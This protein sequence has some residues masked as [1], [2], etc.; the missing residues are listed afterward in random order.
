GVAVD[1]LAGCHA[2]V[3]QRLLQRVV[4][5]GQAAEVGD[6]L[7]QRQ[8]ALDVQ[9][10]DRLV[11]VELSNQLGGTRLEALAV[12]LLPPVGEVAGGVELAALVRSEEHTSEL[13]SREKLVCRL[14]LEKKKQL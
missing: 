7:A 4:G 5:D 1:G 8:L 6:V 13:Q 11:V 2:G 12:G 9:A 3:G 14:L 10:V